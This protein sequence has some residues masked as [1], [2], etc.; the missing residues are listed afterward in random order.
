MRVSRVV[1]NKITCLMISKGGRGNDITVGDCI[2]LTS[3]PQQ[4]HFRGAAQAGHCSAPCSR[5]PV[6]TRNAA[7]RRPGRAGEG[8]RLTRHGWAKIGLEYFRNGIDALDLNFISSDPNLL[9]L[10]TDAE[11]YHTFD[12]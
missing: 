8:C 3:G 10:P 4:L 1:L 12:G 7:A 2:E 9:R 6:R 5:R 11:P